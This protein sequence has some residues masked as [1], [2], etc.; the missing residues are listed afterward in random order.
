MFDIT[1][2]AGG[3]FVEFDTIS[4]KGGV[5]SNDIT[6]TARGVARSR[7]ADHFT[8]FYDNVIS[9]LVIDTPPSI[10]DKPCTL[11]A[12][13]LTNDGSSI[14]TQPVKI[15]EGVVGSDVRT[16]EGITRISVLSVLER[17]NTD[18]Q[19]PKYDGSLARYVFHRGNVGVDDATT[20]YGVLFN[21]EM[22]HLVIKEFANYNDYVGTNRHIWLCARQTSVEFDTVEEVLQALMDE[23]GKCEETLTTAANQ[24]QVSGDATVGYVGTTHHYELRNGKLHQSD[25]DGSYSDRLS[26]IT[27]PLA[28]CFNLGAPTAATS[29]ANGGGWKWENQDL[30]RMIGGK[31]PWFVCPD[32]VFMTDEEFNVFPWMICIDATDSEENN[33]NTTRRLEPYEDWVCDYFYS[34]HWNENFK[35]GLN[36]D[37]PMPRTDSFRIP[38]EEGGTDA[39][40][41]IKG[42]EAASSFIATDEIALGNIDDDLAGGFPNYGKMTI[43]SI[44]TD[45]GYT[46]IEATNNKI[47]KAFGISPFEHGRPLFSMK[48][49]DIAQQDTNTDDPDP[50]YDMW[51]IG[52]RAE[53]SSPNLSKIFRGFYHGVHNPRRFCQHH[54]LGRPGQ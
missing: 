34:Y 42:E 1:D 50:N 3:E 30:A 31:R 53:T 6:L 41:Y 40:L 22:P 37:E 48:A 4:V 51:S 29:S 39:F 16:K 21:Y 20:S 47:Y 33:G 10:I 2:P 17:L 49:L 13:G 32:Q 26:V 18:F 38:A 45:S 14:L 43:D 35:S 27:G 9:P 28:W 24:E 5:T 46:K 7:D 25:K 36:L 44:V 8:S 54:R 23:I 11:W 12:I 19:L 52:Y 15:K